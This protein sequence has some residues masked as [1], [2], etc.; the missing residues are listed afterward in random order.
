MALP[1]TYLIGW[2]EQDRWCYGVRYAR[3][4]HPNDLWTKYFTSSK[5]VKEYRETYGEPDVV[6]VRQTFN[7]SLQ[8]REW[9]EK[10][11]RRLGAVK[12]ERWLNRQNGGKEFFCG[13]QASAHIAK[14]VKSRNGYSHS[15]ET[16]K[17]IGLKSLGRL[18]SSITREKI[19]EK[20]ILNNYHHSEETRKRMSANRKGKT[21]HSGEN[22]PMYG[23]KQPT[24]T[25]EYCF[26]VCSKTNYIRFHGTN[27][28][29]VRIL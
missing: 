15:E 23:K 24:E 3:G 16:R 6:E 2:K 5:S 4:C 8:A 28:K 27:C 22:N 26:L 1:F 19:R 7:D 25:C 20:I 10:V 13:E 14:R 17:K 11:L 29:K 9:E 21:S 18:K 12:S